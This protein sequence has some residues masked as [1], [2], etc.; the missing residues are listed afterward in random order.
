VRRHPVSVDPTPDNADRRLGGVGRSDLARW[1][2]QVPAA[3]G[4][5]AVAR[6]AS[7]LERLMRSRRSVISIRDQ[8]PPTN[9]AAARSLEIGHRYTV[10]G[11]PIAQQGRKLHATTAIFD[12]TGKVQARS[13][14]LWLIPRG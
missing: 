13:R 11:W 6:L 1:P 12:A 5:A 7:H 4:A 3:Q 9:A 10:I 8:S 14:Q 2:Q